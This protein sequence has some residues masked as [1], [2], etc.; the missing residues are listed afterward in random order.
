MSE[1]A[2]SVR[3]VLR[4][5]TSLLLPLP[6]VGCGAEASDGLCGPCTD[7]L[8]AAVPSPPPPGVA[9]WYAAHSYAGAWRAAV[10]AAKSRRSRAVLAVLADHLVAAVGPDELTDIV[11]WPPTTRDRR[12]R[13]GFDQAEVLA[14]AVARSLRR[15]AARLLTR[16]PH[17]SAQQGRG[18][19]ERAV[20]PTFACTRDI[21]GLSALVV[22]DVATTGATLSA[23]ARALRAAGA[24]RVVA[25]T[26]ARTAPPCAGPGGSDSDGYHGE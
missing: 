24:R 10:V 26:A 3:R 6:C 12:R 9:A 1:G 15:P 7:R 20:G 16:D 14:R 25:A 13:R 4:S 22:D 19:A 2:G 23:A 17:S 11:T 5:L 8:A 21:R 18:R